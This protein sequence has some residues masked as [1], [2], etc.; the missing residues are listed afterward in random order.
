MFVLILILYAAA[1]ILLGLY[2]SRKVHQPTDFFVAGRSLGAGLLF[3]TLLAAN[4][5]AGSTV[6]AAGLG[7]R[8][9]FSAWWWVGSAGIGSLILAL[10]VGPRIWQVAKEHDLLTVGDYL[11]FRFDRRVKGFVAVLLWFG[12][13]AI[14]AA[15]L[16][17]IAW[18]LNVV[19]GVSK[20]IGCA[21]GAL[22]ATTY[23]ATGGLYS[24]A[25]VN[26]L[27]LAVKLVGFTLAFFYISSTIGMFMGEHSATLGVTRIGD[28]T[29]YLSFSGDGVT[30]L[31]YLILLAP[32][33]F[34]SPGLLQK[35]FGARDERAVRIGVGIN[36][37]CL[38]A[39]AIIP[40]ALGMAARAQF[41]DLANRELALPTLMTQGLPVWLGGL[42]LGA[43]FA[44]E[45]SSADAVLFMLSTSLSKDLYKT[46]I[47]PG[48]D[49]RRL[50]TVVRGVAV[51][52]G[53]IGGLLAAIL[54]DVISALTIFY[55]L[56]SAAL[57][58]PLIAGLYIS[59]VSSRGALLGMTVS[60]GATLIVGR[61]TNGEGYHGVPALVIG[62][63]AGA[64]VML[65]MTLTERLRN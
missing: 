34:V 58:L 25:R 38:L 18:I 17:A 47:N 21:I 16:I 12:S 20:P 29:A 63:G 32:S 8:D 28:A 33:F 35:V 3:S 11:Q 46:F 19:V 41:P 48:A 9:G 56:L 45:L 61:L 43:T 6:G 4:I 51:A 14:L 10:A 49:D 22:V 64:L 15:Q 31:K 13:L 27:Q 26:V 53:I 36:A 44:A 39:F 37:L 5:G 59:A 1:M 24:T 65:G 57:F 62:I 55:T 54:P 40:A 7:Y 52:C 2:V 23:F 30:P 42:L 50:M 60:V